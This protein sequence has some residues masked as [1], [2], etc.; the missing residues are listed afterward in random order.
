VSGRVSLEVAAQGSGH[1][2]NPLARLEG[3]R[4]KRQRQTLQPLNF[5]RG[6]VPQ[7]AVQQVAA[8]GEVVRNRA[9]GR[10]GLP[11]TARCVTA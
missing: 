4:L 6:G 5:D 11:A 8:C 10:R 7:S 9:E 3:T 2:V 1:V